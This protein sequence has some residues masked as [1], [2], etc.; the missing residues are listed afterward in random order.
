VGGKNGRIFPEIK[1]RSRMRPWLRS[2]RA[3]LVLAVLVWAAGCLLIWWA[4]PVVPRSW[5]PPSDQKSV[6]F[7]SDGRTL[8]TVSPTDS[9][10]AC[11]G[12]VQLWDVDTGRLQAFHFGPDDTFERLWVDPRHDRL[13]VQQRNSDDGL[14][15]DTLELR[16]LD[17]HSAREIAHFTR[18]LPGKLLPGNGWWQ[19]SPDGTTAAFVTVENEQPQIEWYDV[20]RG[21][22]LRTFPGAGWSIHFS[23]DGHRLFAFLAGDQ[24]EG[25]KPFTVWEVPSGREI[26]LFP[27]P[28]TPGDYNSPREF[29]P[30]GELL[31]TDRTKVWEVTTGKLRFQAADVSSA[32]STF[33]ADSRWLIVEHRTKAESWL[34]WYDVVTGEE[35][36][37][38][39]VSL[40]KTRRAGN[41]L[42]RATAD[43][44]FLLS[45]GS[46]IPAGPGP[47]RRQLA[48]LPWLW[49]LGEDPKT[50][51]RWFLIDEKSGR[52]VAHGDQIHC[53]CNPQ[54][55]LL[56]TEDR[57]HRHLLWD[58]P[59]RKPLGWFVALAGVL[60][61]FV[62]LLARWRLGG[63]QPD[64]SAGAKHAL[65]I[66][67]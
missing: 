67:P 19:T 20:A 1:W 36:P 23:P 65:P 44:R 38:K 29:S 15:G 9:Q 39:R 43:G 8:V 33:S 58:V 47:V 16:L 3:T 12:P 49:S 28:T 57:Q 30:D 26:A 53:Q 25:P 2:K 56:L 54:G 24:L 64:A 4:L 62:V 51:D 11:V 18:H 27:V 60:S 10:L 55:T 14:P 35:Q 7:L 31:L 41:A 22:L 46:W 45:T 63:Q 50:K 42:M 48:R 5:Q 13:E 59:P 37:G 40:Q 34:S 61:V 52:V 21:R 17:A 32:F 6:G 66:P